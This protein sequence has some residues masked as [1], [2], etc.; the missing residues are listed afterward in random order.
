MQ[1]SKK[2]LSR[3]LALT[4]TV[5]F[6]LGVTFSATGCQSCGRAKPLAELL[7]SS[8]VVVR[9]T[10]T[11]P[12]EWTGAARGAIFEMGDAVRT[13]RAATAELR[14]DDASLLGLEEQ[15][16][17]RFLERRP[18]E[19]EQSFDLELGSASLEA[20]PSGTQVRTAFGTARLEPGAKVRL[21]RSSDKLRYE[22]LLGSARLESADGSLVEAKRGESFEISLGQA[23]L[24]PVIEQPS[25][26]A[27][28]EPPASPQLAAAEIRASVRGTRVKI[29]APQSSEY[30]ALPAG[31]VTVSPGSRIRIDAGSNVTITQGSSRAELTAGGT[32]LVGGA[33]LVSA[34]S[35]S[36]RISTEDTLLIRVP[37][38]VIETTRGSAVIRPRQGATEVKQESGLSHL[39]GTTTEQLAPGEVGS[40]APDG[41][42]SV[43][44]RGLSHADIDL[45]AGSSLVIHDPGPPSAV[46]FI[47]GKAC[48]QG[49]V[50][51]QG[52]PS[53]LPGP[54]AARGNGAVSL[55]IGPGSAEYALHCVDAQGKEGKALAKGSVTVI[56]DAGHRAMPSQAPSTSVD[57]NGLGYTVLYQNQLPRVS[58][59][60]SKAP[61]STSGFQ[62]TVASKGRTMSY[63]TQQAS[64]IFP[65]GAL[66]P[67][68]HTVHFT[69]GG[70]VSR[71]TKITIRFDNATPTASLATP[72]NTGA[73]P[74][75]SVTIAGTT[76]PGWTATVD[77]KALSQDPQGRFSVTTS[78]PS[79]GHALQVWLNHPSLGSHVYLRRPAGAQ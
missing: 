43:E 51:L 77:G 56:A 22:V 2:N 48:E 13:E 28:A 66:G 71:K 26:P 23:V 69:G 64:Y 65:A 53:A 36:L 63:S 9:D 6:C 14:L 42:V 3:L 10:S 34:E 79:S 33:Q 12:N 61:P 35:G 8:G 76:L 37:G 54:R 17:I 58:L 5:F 67:G 50:R 70:H 40:I 19:Q 52:K 18:G 46:K 62:L 7:K 24:E 39:K 4:L 57:V 25:E 75:G 27:P 38:G 78:M 21:S 47:F 20:S 15:T 74:G 68:T 45:Q 1:T 11:K 29:A 73:A 41:T 44:G 32:Y 59:S 31:E 30:S 55:P 16:L 72:V 60:W 49:V